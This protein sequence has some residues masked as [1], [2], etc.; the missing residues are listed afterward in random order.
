MIRQIQRHLTITEIA[1]GLGAP[2]FLLHLNHLS[3]LCGDLIVAERDAGQ[4]IRLSLDFSK[5][6]V[7]GSKSVL[8]SG[9]NYPSSLAFAD[10]WIYVGEKDKII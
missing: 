8:Q 1:Y 6:N 10:G 9:L 2:R 5:Q 3:P 7:T 4:V